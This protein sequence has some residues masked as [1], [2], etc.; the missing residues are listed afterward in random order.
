MKRLWEY[1]KYGWEHCRQPLP[2]EIEPTGS[3]ATIVWMSPVE[4]TES[5]V[6]LR[7]LRGVL[8]YGEAWTFWGALLDRLRLWAILLVW[9]LVVVAC[10]YWRVR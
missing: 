1:I 9:L 10:L 2:G 4:E 3:G 5:V 8:G 6:L 7:R